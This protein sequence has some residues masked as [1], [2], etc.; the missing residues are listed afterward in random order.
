MRDRLWVFGRRVLGRKGA[1]LLRNLVAELNFILGS[2]EDPRPKPFG[3]SAMVCTYNEEDWVVE[4]ML[5]AKD[6][7]DEFVV[8]DSSTDRTPELVLSL[9][10]EGLNVRLYRVPP[11]DMSA[12][13]Y[14]AVKEAKYRW[15]LQLDADFIFF[16]WAPKYLR[17]FIEGLDERKHY[18]IY[19]PWILICGDLK[20]LCSEEPYHI[21]HWLFTK[22]DRLM[23]RNLI[24]HNQVRD[25]LIAPLRLYKV[26]YIEKPLGLHL[27]VRRRL[28]RHAMK[29]LWSFNAEE[30]RELREKG[31][32]YEEYVRIKARKIY[33]TDDLELI[34]RKLVEE[35]IAK[36][37]PYRGELPSV[38]KG[39]SL[40]Y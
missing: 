39:K 2:Y 30:V 11:G 38:L 37:P 7:V 40:D 19:W 21:E 34:G 3:V 17:E 13:R 28:S 18:L 20:H 35:M 26:K 12:T 14:L 29:L 5:S 27:C 4:S 10:D 16:D 36:L 8:V 33:G 23:Y 1:F 22:S 24:I 6:L 9:R 15:V 32:T 25:H 31:M